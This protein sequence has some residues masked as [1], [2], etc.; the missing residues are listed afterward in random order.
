VR[1]DVL[2]ATMCKTSIIDYNALLAHS[3]VVTSHGIV[4]LESYQPLRYELKA[5]PSEAMNDFGPDFASMGVT[6]EYENLSLSRFRWPEVSA[7]CTVLFISFLYTQCKYFLNEPFVYS[8]VSLKLISDFGVH[9]ACWFLKW[10]PFISETSRIA[11][12]NFA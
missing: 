10:R 2:K 8:L 12:A 11:S 5:F 6:Y 1:C 9:R 4:I 3:K 7:D